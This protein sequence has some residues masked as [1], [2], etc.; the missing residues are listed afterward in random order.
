MVDTTLYPGFPPEV[1]ADYRAKGYWGTRTIGAELRAIAALHPAVEAVVDGERRLTYLEL[2]ERTDAVAQRLLDLGL[3]A[4]DAVLLQVGNTV[5]TVEAL[6]GMTKMGAIPVC[7]LI[8]FGHHE[9]DAI[10][11][12]VGARAH[13][14]QADLPGRDLVALAHEVREAVP[15][16][17]L[18]LTIRGDRPGAHRIDDAPAAAPV[19]VV[20]DPD[21]I[22]VMQL[23]GGTTGTPKAIPRLHAEY[24]YNG[25]ATAERYGYTV[26]SRVAQFM[27][28]VHNLGVHSAV[29]AAH[30]VGATLILGATWEPEL[31][32]DT[33]E[34]EHVEYVGTLTTLIPAVADDPRFE[35]ASAS[36]KRLGLAIPAVPI[37]LFESLT[38]KGV[39]V[40]Q[41]YGMSEGLVCSMPTDAPVAMRRDTVGFPLSPDDE[42]RLVDPETGESAA[43]YGELC[44]RGP[45]TLRGYYNA[46]DHNATAFTPDGYYRTGDLVRF[47]DVAGQ[48]CLKIEG[49]CKDLISRGGEKINAGEIEALLTQ[50]PGVQAAALVAVPDPR[51]GERACAF[52]VV[53]ETQMPDL[54]DVRTFLN[55]LGVARYKWPERLERIDTLPTTPV[56]KVAKKQLR[57]LLATTV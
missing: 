44:V 36:L 17:E 35:R 1:V 25:L 15:S 57:D 46:A 38:A 7:S 43:E 10:G 50:M 19:S 32:L 40:C 23:S 51:L 4:G 24:W 9:L 31:V 11:Q 33:L 18:V 2:D 30:S 42:L 52:L 20:T 37:E 28:V 21:A 6:Y 14:V 56:G 3:R 49:R 48:R 29:F 34:R 22:G 26:G 8:P 54:E 5:E 27:P 16:I 47:I 53:D 45:Y 41:F 55:D 39:T 13:L 12:I